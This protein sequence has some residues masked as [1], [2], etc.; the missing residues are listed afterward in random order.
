MLDLG[1]RRVTDLGIQRSD[2]SGVAGLALDPLD[3]E[4]LDPGQVE[5]ASARMAAFLAGLEGPIQLLVSNSRFD[6]DRYLAA[7]SAGWRSEWSTKTGLRARALDGESG[8][9]AWA[10][11]ISA[12]ADACNLRRI[13]VRLLL[14]GPSGPGSGEEDLRARLERIGAGLTQA[15]IGWRAIDGLGLALELE[16]SFLAGGSALEKAISTDGPLK[17]ADGLE[18]LAFDLVDP[19]PEWIEFGPRSFSYPIPDGR[20]FASAGYVRGLPRAVRPGWLALPAGFDFDMSLSLHISPLPDTEVMRRLAQSEREIAGSHDEKV[21]SDPVAAR[22]QRWRAEDVGALAEALRGRERYFKLGAYYLVGAE[23]SQ[24]LEQHRR[25]LRAALAAI[26]LVGSDAVGY[27]RQALQSVLPLARERLVRRR[28][29]TSSPL[30]AA[31]PGSGRGRA[32]PD[33]W[34]LAGCGWDK[35][36]R[37]AFAFNPFAPGYENPHL[38]VLG[39]SGAGK[40]HLARAITYS[41]WLSGAEV[42]LID[43]KNEY[44]PLSRRCQ[45][46]EIALE[47][48]G[49]AALNVFDAV[50]S[51]ERTY[52]GGIADITRFWS[53]ALGKISDHQLAILSTAIEQVCPPV[54]DGWSR[55]PLAS[56][57]AAALAG[58]RS[59][60]GAGRAAAQDLAQRLRRFC[61]PALGRLFSAPTNVRLDNDFLLFELARLRAQDVDLFALAVRLALLAL[62]RWLDR[63]AA[64]RLILIDEAWCLLHDRAG[65]RFLLDLAKTARARGAMLLMVTQDAADFAAN[66]LARSVLA[67]CAAGIIF[68]QHRAHAGALAELFDL[69][70]EAAARISTLRRGQAL[71]AIGGGERVA[72]EVFDHPW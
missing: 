14:A 16:R 69:D 7:T 34:L 2:G 44:R 51:D 27:Q 72:I 13:R 21:D 67:N 41:A 66:P 40:T 71:A 3:L 52:A 20:R 1:V 63:P 35:G 24:A 25:S 38:A 12:A 55:P 10:A 32:D 19:L 39:Q 46:S 59:V 50:G 58:D 30:A 45:G 43:P 65:A 42:A 48:G 29:I 28:G 17:V 26:G 53:A 9:E 31:H 11:R 22:E 37:A 4:S 60:D 18:N 5:S 62:T 70:S 15:G 23:S 57:L 49:A 8:E 68:R 56:D 36:P 33:G 54:R 61:G 64:R 6:A 47:L